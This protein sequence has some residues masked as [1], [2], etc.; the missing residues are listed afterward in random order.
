MRNEVR[1]D[2]WKVW[3]YAAAAVALGAWISPLLYNA[4]K[5]LAEVAARKTTND[6][7]QWLANPLPAGGF[8]GFFPRRA[9]AGGGSV[10]F[11]VDRVAPRS[12]RR[13]RG[14]AGSN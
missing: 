10:I 4:G 3:L 8:P 5:A 9:V 12:S 11:P 2:V 13:R 7:L 1:G 14:G 6:A